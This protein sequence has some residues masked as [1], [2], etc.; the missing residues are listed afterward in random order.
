MTN[1]EKEKRLAALQALL[2][3]EDE[4]KDKEK[5]TETDDDREDD[6]DEKDDEKNESVQSHLKAIF[7][8]T[9]LS[10]E[11]K[12][13]IAILFEAAVNYETDKKVAEISEKLEAEKEAAIEEAE[14]KLK[15]DA[16]AY[17]SY[18]VE[19]WAEQNQMALKQQIKVD[20]FESF[21]GG[22][23]NLFEEHNI[24][25]PEG[26]EDMLESLMEKVESLES[27]VKSLSRRNASLSEE[28]DAK[29]KE[30][31]LIKLSEGLTKLDAEK[32]KELVESKDFASVEDFKK[33]ASLIKESYFKKGTGATI[34][35]EIEESTHETA[36]KKN[37]AV[38]VY[39]SMISAKFG[40]K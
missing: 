10:E 37:D 8:G 4:D 13:K 5:K 3:E 9:E 38:S 36:V 20:I 35:E 28:I 26:K 14:A 15:E 12:E 39:A 25:V 1:E 23:H 11:A 2:A 40:K 34:R 24:S 19:E 27:D 18:V 32:F 29:E 21:I 30:L 7:D 16:D 6:E 31:H 22:L 33:G 17:L